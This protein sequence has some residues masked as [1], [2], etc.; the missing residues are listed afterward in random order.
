MKSILYFSNNLSSELHSGYSI[1]T[2]EQLK[3]LSLENKV[4]L[5]NFYTSFAYTTELDIEVINIKSS[6]DIWDRLSLPHSLP[7]NYKEF[8]YVVFNSPE[9]VQYIS[10]FKSIKKIYLVNNSQYQKSRNTG[11]NINNL[12]EKMC[13]LADINLFL[14][15][16]D[17]IYFKSLG[18]VR[19]DDEIITPFINHN[20]VKKHD[21]IPKTILITTNFEAEYNKESLRW[22]LEEVYPLLPTDIRISISGKGDFDRISKEYKNIKFLSFVTRD[23]LINLYNTNKLYINPTIHGSGI[24]IK[25][26]EALSYGIQVVSTN[27][28]NIFP[29]VIPSSD[30]PEKLA[31]L[32][33]ANLDSK[34]SFNFQHFNSINSSRFLKLFAH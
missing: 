30:N 18:L 19:K 13:K 32:I 6:F 14:S 21:R 26:L 24:Q 8:Q 1:V 28:S 25:M 10:K 33:V 16:N 4:T 11:L 22:F 5:I 29:N 17:F 9:Q 27:Y 31:N 23:E 12:E 15:N 34:S 3:I 20:Q 7:I 2:Y